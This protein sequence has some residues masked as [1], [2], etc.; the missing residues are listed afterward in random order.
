[1]TACRFGGRATSGGA[2]HERLR[3]RGGISLFT[4][5]SMECRRKMTSMLALQH[6]DGSGCRHV[7]VSP[8][9]LCA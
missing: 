3:K 4:M 8:G 1:M 6:D 2:W 7:L 9:D 5:W